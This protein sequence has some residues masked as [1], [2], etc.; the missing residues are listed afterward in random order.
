MKVSSLVVLFVSIFTTLT[1]R[2]DVSSFES[3]PG[4]AFDRV[5]ACKSA[6]DFARISTHRDQEIKSFSPCDCTSIDEKPMT[7]K[8][9][10]DADIVDKKK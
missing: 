9:T 8:C 6:K 7:W 2:A 3:A 4:A 1:V 5:T 10:V